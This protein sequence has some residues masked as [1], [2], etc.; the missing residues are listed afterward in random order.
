MKAIASKYFKWSAPRR[1]GK[2]AYTRA[3]KKLQSQNHAKFHQKGWEVRVLAPTRENSCSLRIVR[4]RTGSII[5]PNNEYWKRSH[6][7]ILKGALPGGRV[8]SVHARAKKVAVSEM[9]EIALVA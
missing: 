7:N 8:I 4:N 2:L 5:R 1:A 6:A 9:P 3:L